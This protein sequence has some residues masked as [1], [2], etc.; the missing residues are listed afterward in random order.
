VLIVGGVS[1]FLMR[2]RIERMLTMAS[3]G[4]PQDMEPPR[5]RRRSSAKAQADV[6][7]ADYRV[8]DE[9]PRRP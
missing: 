4:M 7:D 5:P 3:R 9:P 6:V 1:A 2:K 8:V